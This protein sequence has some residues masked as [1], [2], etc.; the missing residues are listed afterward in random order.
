[1]FT[2]IQLEEVIK[3]CADCLY[4]LE[5]PNLRN[6]SFV[7]LLEIATQEFEFGFNN[8]V[9]CQIGGIAMSSHLVPTLVNIF[10]GYLE[11][12]VLPDFESKVNYFRYGW[13]LHY[14]KKWKD[15]FDIVW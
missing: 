9:Y 1:M 5:N 15:Y 6:D 4:S 2:S 10:M 8:T 12:K 11:Y 7:R 14:H 13:L 3:I